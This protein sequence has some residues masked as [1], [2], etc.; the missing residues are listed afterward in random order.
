M[1]VFSLLHFVYILWVRSPYFFHHKT[2]TE[3]TNVY[4]VFV[5]RRKGC[6]FASQIHRP[7]GT[8]T[9]DFAPKNIPP[10]CFLYG[11]HPLRVRIPYPD[12]NNKDETTARV[13]SSLLAR[14][15]GF[16][17][18][19]FWF[20]VLQVSFY[21]YLFNIILIFY[22][23]LYING[24]ERFLLQNFLKPIYINKHKKIHKC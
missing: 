21:Y 14:R 19:T 15:K 6:V 8:A 5:A 23:P 16:E 9:S 2:K 24:F 10:E 17:P 13:I 3:Y 7:C 12:Y 22:K 1:C 4:S 20:V 11:A 18:P